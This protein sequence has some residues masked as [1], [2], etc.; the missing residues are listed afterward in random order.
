M[1]EVKAMEFE[2]VRAIAKANVYY[3]GKVLS[4][5]IYLP[6]GER[7]TFGITFPGEYEFGTAAAEVMDVV[8]GSLHVMLPGK[9]A[10]ETYTPGMSFSIPAESK[11]KLKCDELSEYVCSYVSE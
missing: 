1:S 2:N 8:S 5:T 4:H 9:S 11:F 3:D 6:D 10:W 7:K